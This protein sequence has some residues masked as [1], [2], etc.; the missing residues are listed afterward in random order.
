MTG[1]GSGRPDAE[2]VAR[3]LEVLLERGESIA[4]AESLTGGLLAAAIT[5]RPGASEVFMGSVTAYATAIKE[6]L[7][8]VAGTLLAARGAVDP[9]VAMAM[10][11][12][13]RRRL[14]ATYGVATTG[15]AGPDSQ[16]GQPV[17]TVFVAVSGPTER[18]VQRLELTGDRR[19]IR[20]AAVSQAL[21]LL[22]RTFGRNDRRDPRR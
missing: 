19:Q 22:D 5:E 8:G 21:A 10:A 9:E 15:V 18:S 7:L 16:D 1:S 6:R 3:I 14:G 4:I 20:A 11:D 2:L 13:V 12:G 17:G